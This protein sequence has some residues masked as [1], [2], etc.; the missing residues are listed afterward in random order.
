[1]TNETR[2]LM[3][4]SEGDSVEVKRIKK[5]FWDMNDSTRLYQFPEPFESAMNMLAETVSLLGE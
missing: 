1:M 4:Q 2:K 3:A 5:L